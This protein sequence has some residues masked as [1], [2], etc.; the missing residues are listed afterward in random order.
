MDGVNT[1]KICP[2]KVALKYG[3]LVRRKAFFEECRIYRE[4][5]RMG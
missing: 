2:A 5:C 4:K 3:I 1:K